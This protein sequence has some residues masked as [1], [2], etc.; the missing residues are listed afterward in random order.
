[1]AGSAPAFAGAD[2]GTEPVTFQLSNAD[3]DLLCA[4]IDPARWT[5]TGKRGVRFRDAEQRFAGGLTRGTLKLRG[6]GADLAVTSWTLD[7]RSWGTD[8]RA[9][10][11]VGSRCAQGTATLRSRG[12]KGYAY[13]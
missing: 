3:G 4:T 2:A 8:L 6:G 7:M 10:L 1:V 12:R 9:T 11:R 13:P 5:G